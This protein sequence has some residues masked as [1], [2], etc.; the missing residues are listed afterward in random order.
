[1]LR[2]LEDLRH[3]K[4]VHRMRDLSTLQAFAAKEGAASV[5]LDHQ[6]QT[7]GFP[8]AD[9]LAFDQT[10]SA[11]GWVHLVCRGNR[12]EVKDKG[13]I[14]KPVGGNLGSNL[15]LLDA[16]EKMFFEFHRI[17]GDRR[18]TCIAHE[19]PPVGRTVKGSG[20][21]S[22]VAATALRCAVR[23]ST[24]A[25]VQ[26]IAAQTWKKAMAGNAKAEKIEA[27]N[28]LVNRF[29]PSGDLPTNEGQR[30]ALCIAVTALGRI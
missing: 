2:R 23:N 29:A 6:T 3:T 18:W 4:V 22:L 1:M 26:V 25:P 10:V 24:G 11:T 15:V 12:L 17:I 7:I 20:S 5:A 21:S 30:D 8:D 13:S 19:L 9:I 27:Y 14:A 16:A 28:G